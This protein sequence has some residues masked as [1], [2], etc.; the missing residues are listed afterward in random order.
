[1]VILEV[2]LKGR[3]LI[4]QRHPT[5][6]SARKTAKFVGKAGK[7]RIISRGKVVGKKRKKR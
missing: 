3:K 7:V 1:M 2:K 4:R 5:V 6:K